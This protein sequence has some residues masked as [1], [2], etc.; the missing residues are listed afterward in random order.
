M[1]TPIKHTPGQRT[2]YTVALKSGLLVHIFGHSALLCASSAEFYGESGEMT[3]LVWMHD[4]RRVDANGL[5]SEADA[6]TL[7]TVEEARCA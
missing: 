7:Y 1:T 5:Y 6:V 3:G 4:I 2:H